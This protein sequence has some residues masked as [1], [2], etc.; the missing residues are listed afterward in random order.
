MTDKTTIN[1]SLLETALTNAVKPNYVEDA[2]EW[3]LWCGDKQHAQIILDAAKAYLKSLSFQSM[4]TAPKTGELIICWMS[5][6]KFPDQ[7]AVIYYDARRE[8]W[9]W[10]YSEDKIK[11]PDL[12]NG[13]MKW[14]EPPKEQ[15]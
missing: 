14:H 2:G 5:G 15:E 4:D 7:T 8:S 3:C 1:K 13:W 9:C 12:L 11:R 6:D 10:Y